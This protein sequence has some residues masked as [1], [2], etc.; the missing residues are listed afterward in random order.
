[1]CDGQRIIHAACRTGNVEALRLLTREAPQGELLTALSTKVGKEPCTPLEAAVIADNRN[2]VLAVVQALCGEAAAEAIER[3]RERTAEMAKGEADKASGGGESE[4]GSEPIGSDSEAEDIRR[5]VKKMRA[6]KAER[7]KK[8]FS[9]SSFIIYAVM[10]LS[11]ITPI[12]TY[13]LPDPV[14]KPLRRMKTK[15]KSKGN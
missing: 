14:P 11:M 3:A 12:I 7:Q 5:E 2:N 9:W 4:E 13:V 15:P 8:P 10:F 1:V 6:S